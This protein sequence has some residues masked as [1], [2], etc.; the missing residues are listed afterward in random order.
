MKKLLYRLFFEI[1][2]LIDPVWN[3]RYSSGLTF[4]NWYLPR[5]EKVKIKNQK[6]AFTLRPVISS[7]DER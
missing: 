3:D 1:M 5:F 6:K 7:I 4:N 2:I